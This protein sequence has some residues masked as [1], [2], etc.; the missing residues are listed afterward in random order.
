GNPDADGGARMNPRWLRAGLAVLA[1]TVALGGCVS[2]PTGGPVGGS[3]GSIHGLNP[4]PNADQSQDGIV[5]N[6]A[7]PGAQW[8]PGQ[9]VSG[10]L[11]ASGADQDVARQY[12]TP[13]YS[14]NW[15]PVQAVMVLDT[16]LDVRGGPIPSHV[17][18]GPETAQITVSSRDL[19]TLTPT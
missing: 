7:R 10:F 13:G 5:V 2:L 9:I 6:P 1:A 8:L 17:T 16:N 11:A 4:A 19:E 14:K 12:L 3:N 15:K 18:G